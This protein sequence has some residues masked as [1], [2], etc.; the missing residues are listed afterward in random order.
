[1]SNF[2]QIINQIKRSKSSMSVGNVWMK[3]GGDRGA[4]ALKIHQYRQNGWLYKDGTADN[5]DNCYRVSLVD[6]PKGKYL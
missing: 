5:G 2:C 4:I 6:C 1:M 3:V